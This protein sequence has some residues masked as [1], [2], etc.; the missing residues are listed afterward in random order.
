VG[1]HF[2]RLQQCD[3][4]VQ[5]R[6]AERT[7]LELLRRLLSG[8]AFYVTLPLLVQD[9]ARLISADDVGTEVSEVI[10]RLDAEIGRRGLAM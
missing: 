10:N 9:N 8:A 2:G 7:T 5:V 4:A 3:V 1:Q 6:N